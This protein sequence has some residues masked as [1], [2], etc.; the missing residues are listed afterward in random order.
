M[1][2]L[3]AQQQ[4]INTVNGESEGDIT[5][6]QIRANRIA[7]TRQQQA[8]TN[9]A[10][11][12]QTGYPVTPA[13]EPPID[14]LQEILNQQSPP[15]VAPQ[16]PQPQVPPVPQPPVQQPVQTIPQP[17]APQPQVPADP[18]PVQQQLQGDEPQP[19]LLPE[20]QVV[21]D[22]LN[23]L[24]AEPQQE[25]GTPQQE[26]LDPTVAALL[27]Q[28]QALQAQLNAAQ[29]QP[30]FAPQPPQADPF[31]AN[32][33]FQWGDPNQQGFQAPPLAPAPP[34]P[35]QGVDPNQALM[36]NAIYQL[37][38]QMTQVQQQNSD[39]LASQRRDQDVQSLMQA[40]GINRQ[41]AERAMDYHEKGNIQA[42]AEVINL[43]S[44]PVIARQTHA[45][46]RE[47][48]RDAAG[49]SLTPAPQ[50]GSRTTPDEMQAKMAEWNAIQSM[51]ATTQ[52]QADN[53]KLAIVSY[54]SANPE[55][56]A[57]AQQ[58]PASITP[59]VV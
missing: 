24:M 32:P 2:D 39:F 33:A 17:V 37:S 53:K 12:P 14:P 3:N 6:E 50:G 29:Q 10:F 42:A 19:D 52:G 5:Q 58:T 16:V 51:P 18:N 36:G 59:P 7:L 56:I 55:I 9:Q 40:N 54:I 26:T 43:A 48:R 11:D 35:P 49:Q 21:V 1:N 23:T 34:M 25:Q 47:V 4:G 41:H 57:Q 27:Q 44:A 45:H 15:V 30:A 13:N 46:E 22:R 8:E 31:G 38:Q 20:E 28:N